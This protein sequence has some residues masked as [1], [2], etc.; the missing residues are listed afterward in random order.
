MQW[1]QCIM[2]YAVFEWAVDAFK[3]TTNIDDK[4]EFVKR[5]QETKMADSLAGPI[6]YTV[7]VQ[8][9]TSHPTLNCVTTPTY[10]GQ[11]RLSNGGK[12]M[13]ELVVVSNVTTPIVA[14]QDKLKPVTW[15]G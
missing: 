15:A 2:H 9:G 13:F 12:Y 11:W 8:W 4:E 7:P 14:V 5:V 3:R 6:D 1:Q 10:G